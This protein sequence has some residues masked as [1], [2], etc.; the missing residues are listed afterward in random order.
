MSTSQLVHQVE[1][2][3]E[4]ILDEIDVFGSAQNTD[5]SILATLESQISH[6]HHMS[7]SHTAQ[8]D[9]GSPDDVLYCIKWN[10]QSHMHNTW[11]TAAELNAMD[12]KGIRKLANY[13]QH[14]A[15]LTRWRE[16]ATLEELEYSNCRIEQARQLTVSYTTVERVIEARTGENRGETEYLCKWEGLPYSSATW[17]TAASIS[18]KFQSK[19][20]EH[21]RRN[22]SKTLPMHSP[23]RAKRNHFRRLNFQPEFLP[24]KVTLRDY[25]L[26]G[27][28]WLGMSW[29]NYNSV[30]LADEM[31][32]S[33][34]ASF[35]FYFMP[36]GFQ[37]WAKPFR[38]S[39]F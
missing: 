18:P 14:E 28:N 27:L 15:E 6:Q 16:T 26:D 33:F 20:D 30:I 19:I 9:E 7:E 22:S 31:G 5:D 2:E 37:A 24:E 8:Q 4:R 25:Q 39:R 12:I 10:G 3:K 11:H 34:L 36:M 29:C 38:P 17:E 21:L 13:I 35:I 1:E 32:L 23:L